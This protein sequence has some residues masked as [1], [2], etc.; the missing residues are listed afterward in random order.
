[1][2]P[3]ATWA[4]V[5]AVALC[6]CA[7]EPAPT[8]QLKMDT[9][10]ADAVLSIIEARAA[11]RQPAE[12]D[13]QRLFATEPYIRLQQREAQM[14]RDFTDEQFREFVLSAKLAARG[15][16]MRATLEQW[17]RAELEAGAERVLA[18]LPAGARIRA[19]VYPMI[20][21]VTNSFVFDVGTDPAIF[22]YLDPEVSR[23]K[24]EN[25][26][27]HELH[28]IGFASLSDQ[29]DQD[30]QSYPANVHSALEWMGA[31]GEGFAMLAAAGGPDADP[32][33]VSTAEER[34]IWERDL[35]NF[36]RDLKELESF[37]LDVIQGR[38]PSKDEERKKA[39]SFFGEAQ[40]PWY[41]VGW[42]MAQ[43]VEKRYGRVVLLEC[44][45]HPQELLRAYNQVAAEHNRRGEAWELWSEELLTAVEPP[46]D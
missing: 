16:A 13:W 4:A 26:V 29:M 38:F 32:H 19:K 23:L 10:E 36:N 7:Q 46:S 5:C 41:T 22:L 34:A 37:F 40:G 42:R 39:F 15:P 24:F 30:L 20:K 11:G 17:K 43:M 12:A 35:A 21:P 44:M 8:V 27:A 14:K 28:H 31:F 33:A 25:T 6:A 3:F 1:M 45:T 9:S 18:Y 2:R